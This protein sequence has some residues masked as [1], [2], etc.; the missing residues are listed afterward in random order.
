MHYVA[1]WC[2]AHCC[3]LDITCGENILCLSLFH[4]VLGS[5]LKLP[6]F[7]SHQV[8]RFH[9]CSYKK[10]NAVFLVAILYHG[11]Q[12]RQGSERVFTSRPVKK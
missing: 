7:F 6:F 11:W 9:S 5:K 3:A 12:H 4:V 10:K 8:S 1:Q 2:L